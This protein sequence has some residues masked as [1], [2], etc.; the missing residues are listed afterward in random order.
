V[1]ARAALNVQADRVL[2]IEAAVLRAVTDI[3]RHAASPPRPAPAVSIA[4]MTW[5]D[6]RTGG[7]KPM[8]TLLPGI[9]AHR[10]PTDRLT[11]AVPTT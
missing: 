7:R 6:A 11:V 1:R 3:G 5:A 9:A 8:E 10:V 2:R 4:T